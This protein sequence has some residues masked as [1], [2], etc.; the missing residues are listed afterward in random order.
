[1]YQLLRGKTEQE[2]NEYILRMLDERKKYYEKAKITIN[3]S[4][5]D[6]VDIANTINAAIN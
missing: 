2:L 1:M 6:I 3:A 5:V 4:N